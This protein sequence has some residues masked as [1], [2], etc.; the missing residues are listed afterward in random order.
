LKR[1]DDKKRDE[2]LP[3]S[4]IQFTCDGFILDGKQ[5][6]TSLTARKQLLSIVG[7]PADFFL[8][9]LNPDEQVLIFNRICSQKENVKL[10]YRLQDNLLYG[11]VSQRYTKLDNINIANI[12][13]TKA[14][15]ELNLSPVVV[16]L[17]P[18]YSKFRFIQKNGKKDEI[19]PL[20]EFTNSE[21]G[22]GS[23]Q[24]WSGAFRL[25]C[26]N[27]LLSSV[28]QTHSRWIHLGNAD[29]KIPD[30]KKVLENSIKFVVMLEQARSVYLNTGQKAEIIIRISRALGQKVGE[31][32]VEV[33]NIEYQGGNNLFNLVNAVTRAAQ[34][35]QPAVQTNI[36]S[37]AGSLLSS[38]GGIY[39]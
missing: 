4:A 21:N 10:M 29:L 2:L 36:E 31:R 16:K 20:I 39:H 6:Q 7:I 14:F 13:K 1:Y 27:G 22:L 11:I 34:D 12:L 8:Q 19:V 35:F 32:V 24:V 25:V 15:D 26:E 38:E 3:M 30:L 9:S 33:A 17:N 37:Y 28:Q 18:D 23:M 5:I